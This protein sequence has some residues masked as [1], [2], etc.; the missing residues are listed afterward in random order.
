MASNYLE[1]LLYKSGVEQRPEET[2][3]GGPLFD[4]TPHHF[5]KWKLRVLAKLAAAKQAP[6][7]KR[8]Y[9]C[10]LLA[11]KLLDG[12]TG[13]AADVAQEF[14]YEKLTAKGGVE[15]LLSTMEDEVMGHSKDE[16]RE[17]HDIGT[18][19]GRGPM[20]RQHGETFV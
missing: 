2:K 17:L 5:E 6:E 14:G 16:A 1:G 15:A 20:C 8:D 9:E 19:R 11:S 13:D 18:R 4:G 10:A 7:E 12:L 3:T